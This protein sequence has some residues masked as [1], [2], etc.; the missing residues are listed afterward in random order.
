MCSCKVRARSIKVIGEMSCTTGP[1]VSLRREQGR[2]ALFRSG[3]RKRLCRHPLTSPHE[4][5]GARKE[6]LGAVHSLFIRPSNPTFETGD[7]AGP[8]DIAKR[9][10]KELR[11]RIDEFKP[12]D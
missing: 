6:D 9:K 10:R 8:K 2:I 5:L 7:A 3:E 1:E 12:F 11:H 4:D